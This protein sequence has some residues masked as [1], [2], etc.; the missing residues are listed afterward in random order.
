MAELPREVFRQM[1]TALSANA[2]RDIPLTERAGWLPRD[3]HEAIAKGWVVVDGPDGG[4]F[5]QPVQI[6]EIGRRTLEKMP[7]PPVGT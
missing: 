2:F 5:G 7:Y 1:L 6:T 4:M 3:V